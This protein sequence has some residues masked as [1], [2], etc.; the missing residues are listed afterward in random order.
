MLLLIRII[1]LNEVMECIWRGFHIFF[2]PFHF[3]LSFS[4]KDVADAFIQKCLSEMNVNALC[5]WLSE[6]KN[7]C[8]YVSQISDVGFFPRNL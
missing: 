2:F 5:T 6:Y 3:F 1:L 7:I 8:L 4:F